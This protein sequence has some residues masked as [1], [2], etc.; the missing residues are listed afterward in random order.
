M[1][2][3][4]GSNSNPAVLIEE[5]ELQATFNAVSGSEAAQE[6]SE[7]P[8][9]RHSQTRLKKL[10]P[11]LA[12]PIVVG[13]CWYGYVATGYESTDDAQVQGHVMQLSARVGGQVQQV[14]VIE[15]QQ[16]HAGDALV[17]IDPKDYQIEVDQARANLADAEATA[18]SSHLNVPITTASAFSS[19]DS[20]RTAVGNA[21]AGVGAA[22]HNLEAAK[23]ELEQAEANAARTDADLTRYGQLV[24]KE[25]ISR[26]QYDQA[27]AAAKANRAGVVSASAAVQSAEQSLRQ[28]QGRLLQ[29]QAD[30]R[31]AETAPDQVSVVRAKADGAAAQVKRCKAV[32]AQA[33]LNLI[34]T[35][36]RT[37][38]S[39]IVGKKSAEVAQNVSVGQQLVIIVPLDDIWVTANF[40]ETQLA[41]MRPG[42]AVEIKVDAYGR[43]WKGHITNLGG[44]TGSV[45]SL[46]PP[47]N[48]T[49]N[50]VKVVQRV[51]VRI[52]FDRS[53]G[54]DFNSDGLLKSG[55]SVEPEA[56][57]R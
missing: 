32:L 23:A 50:Y 46:L 44:G 5:R 24:A 55:L 49:G 57:V 8:E 4:N 21:E 3:N 7:R 9:G 17:V 31:S 12:L 6:T 42:Q 53:P 38:V 28:A 35:V 36:I 29:A 52:D 20:A 34:Y 15:G 39:G 2:H 30:Q 26:Q 45:F 11:L 40:K 22:K 27:V 54:Q 43:A 48:A 18:A 41:H 13:A 25:D 14:N 33:E 56:Q 19:L 47:E 10:L 16:V 37:P 51:P 1:S